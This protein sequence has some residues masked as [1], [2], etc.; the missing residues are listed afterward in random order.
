MSCQVSQLN[1][2]FTVA[3]TN[4]KRWTP[5][6]V[7]CSSYPSLPR[8]LYLWETRQG[9]RPHLLTTP[10]ESTQSDRH[11]A[12]LVDEQPWVHT[13]QTRCGG[14]MRIGMPRK[15]GFG[16]MEAAIFGSP[17]VRMS[18]AARC[19]CLDRTQQNQA[20]PQSFADRSQIRVDL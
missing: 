19:G 5:W 16:A 1:D 14:S 8:K 9:C 15:G 20:K 4:K 17:C 7:G 3:E 6:I 13:T 11:R 10:L 2:D 18:G 12:V